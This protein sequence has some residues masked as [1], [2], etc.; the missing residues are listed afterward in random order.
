MRPSLTKITQR[1]CYAALHLREQ[2]ARY[3]TEVKREHGIGFS[4]RIGLHSGEVVVGKIGDDR[5]NY[6]AQ[7]HTV[8]L[9]QRMESL[10]S[11]DPAQAA[12]LARALAP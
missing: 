3:A 8:G 5:M 1:G 7:G 12:R 4:T 11:P 2:L 9:A 10:A 6:T